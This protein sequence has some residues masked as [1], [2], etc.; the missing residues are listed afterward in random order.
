MGITMGSVLPDTAGEAAFQY[1]EEFDR[2][3]Y[4]RGDKYF[5]RGAVGEITR[6]DSTSEWT[7]T[8][9]GTQLY[10][11]V[12]SLEQDEWFGDC[13]CPVG[14]DCKHCCAT[15]LGILALRSAGCCRWDR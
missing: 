6:D 14:V 12:L 11:V 2:Q 4:G 8:V 7:A 10:E 3:T 9:R 13:T 1:L 15:M 5:L